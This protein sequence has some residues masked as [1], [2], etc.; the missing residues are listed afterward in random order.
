MKKHLL[1]FICFALWQP[2]G[3][4]AAEES[5]LETIEVDSWHFGLS[6]GYG[7]MLSP[8]TDKKDI[9]LYVLPDIRYFGEYFS[10][11][12]TNL[13]YS[14]K[15][16]PNYSIELVGLLNQ[17]GLFF[18]HEFR[19]ATATVAPPLEISITPD[20]VHAGVEQNDLVIYPKKKHLSY[21]A[22]LAWRYHGDADVNLV[23]VSDVTA[24]HHGKEL[25]AN[26]KKQFQLGNWQLESKVGL[27]Y[28]DSALVDYYYGVKEDDLP[29]G[30][31]YMA[32]RPSAAINWHMQLQLAYPLNENLWFV[33]S[34]RYDN[35]D[36]EIYN[37]P[38]VA[39]DSFQSY[40]FG[41]KRVL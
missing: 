1:L 28:K 5:A 10:L 22:G 33:S 15:E 3:V 24:G 8:L 12:N 25:H 40:F 6:L 20:P 9:S 14:L 34:Y 7:Q 37:S 29:A 35:N 19:S 27:S 26:I 17:D 16:T 21:M 36:D 31:E 13:G 38:V 30:F 11:E 39:K 23:L 4:Y 18:P 32:Y 41:I 2:L